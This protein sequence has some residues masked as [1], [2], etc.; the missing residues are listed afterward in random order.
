MSHKRRSIEDNGNHK[1]YFAASMNQKQGISTDHEKISSTYFDEVDSEFFHTQFIQQ[2]TEE[3]ELAT[4]DNSTDESKYVEL[5]GFSQTLSESQFEDT[6]SPGQRWCPVVANKTQALNHSSQ[7]FI[8][9][10]NQQKLNIT[11]LQYNDNEEAENEPIDHHQSSQMFLNDISELNVNIDPDANISVNS[12]NALN[13]SELNLSKFDGFDLYKSKTFAEYMELQRDMHIENQH[14]LEECDL[15]Q[16]L[17]SCYQTQYQRDIESAFNECERTIRNLDDAKEMA[18]EGVDSVLKD[19]NLDDNFTEE[20]IAN[21]EK[22]IQQETK[23]T[24]VIP[25][26]KEFGGD[27]FKKPV[28]NMPLQRPV[29]TSTFCSLGPFFGLPK[30]VKNLIK[31]YKGIDELY[32]NLEYP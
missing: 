15:S 2:I 28:T 10:Q 29:S 23:K 9:H 20:I 27:V 31:E 24:F 25:P 13:A 26:P 4:N 8:Q 32:G 30:K 3:E 7:S 18:D 1:K 14:N 19:I 21:N 22:K 17:D 6:I 16:T 5:C 11:N 12:S